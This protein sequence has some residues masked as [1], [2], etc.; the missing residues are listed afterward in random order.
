MK[1]LIKVIVI[2]VVG[3]GMIKI[4]LWIILIIEVVF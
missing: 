3:V 4:I 1:F 2:Y